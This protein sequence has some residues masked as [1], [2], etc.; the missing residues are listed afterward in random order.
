MFISNIWSHVGFAGFFCIVRYERNGAGNSYVVQSAYIDTSRYGVF[1][2][3][4]F[5]GD[6]AL[7]RVELETGVL[8]AIGRTD[9]ATDICPEPTPC[10]TLAV[11]G[12]EAGGDPLSEVDSRVSVQVVTRRRPG[13]RMKMRMKVDGDDLG[14]ARDE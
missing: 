1:G 12:S 14:R 4:R 10:H 13:R 6:L 9:L 2:K 3:I 5:T 7:P 11:R 8:R